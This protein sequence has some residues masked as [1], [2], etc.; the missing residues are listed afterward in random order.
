MENLP[1]LPQPLD[2]SD[3]GESICPMKNLLFPRE[4]DEGDGHFPCHL[5]LTLASSSMQMDSNQYSCRTLNSADHEVAGASQLRAANMIRDDN[6]DKA[7]GIIQS[8]SADA[9]ATAVQQVT[10]SSHQEPEAP[11]GTG[12]DVFW[13]RF[14]TERPCFSDTEEASSGIKANPGDEQQEGRKS[15]NENI[16]KDRKNMEQ[17]TL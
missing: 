4:V 1:L 16:W 17:L 9:R 5:N 2:L 8:T 14:L 3:T 12:N 13:E 11:Q 7:V 6:V 15:A 10:P